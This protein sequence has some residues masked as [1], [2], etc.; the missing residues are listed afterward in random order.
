MRRNQVALAKVKE[1]GEFGGSYP[2]ALRA[3]IIDDGVQWPLARPFPELFCVF[4]DVG[5]QLPHQM[6]H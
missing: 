3:Y 2:F 1:L 6:R 4:A 5:C